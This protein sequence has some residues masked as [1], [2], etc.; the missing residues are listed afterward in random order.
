[1][2]SIG[3]YMEGDVKA[4]SPFIVTGVLKPRYAITEKDLSN[5]VKV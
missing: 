4:H 3:E 5:W 2:V 1:M